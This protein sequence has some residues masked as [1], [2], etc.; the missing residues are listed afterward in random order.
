VLVVD[1]ASNGEV[2]PLHCFAELEH[3]ENGMRVIYD[4]P[5]NIIVSLMD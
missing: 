5:C 3:S 2:R 1:T 4:S